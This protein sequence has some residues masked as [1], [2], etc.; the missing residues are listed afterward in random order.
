MPATPASI[1]ALILAL[2]AGSAAAT[3][4]LHSPRALLRGVDFVRNAHRDFEV[5]IGE[6]VNFG[7]LRITLRDC[8]FLAHNPDHH[9]Y[10]FLEVYETDSNL[11]IFGAWVLSSS[12]ALSAIDHERYDVWLIRCATTA[13]DSASG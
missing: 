11:K 5:S 9:S 3:Q 13:P 10:A 7:K 8:R 12:P 1:F 6:T 2:V 4:A